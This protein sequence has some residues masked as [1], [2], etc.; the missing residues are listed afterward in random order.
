[1]LNFPRLTIDLCVEYPLAE[2]MKAF[3]FAHVRARVR[4]GT[5]R[6]CWI[7]E[8]QLY[9]IRKDLENSS[10]ECHD[11]FARDA[12]GFSWHIMLSH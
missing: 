11:L 4:K 9:R 12:D 1:M 7:S 6:D 5:I 2:G 3:N 8:R 10:L